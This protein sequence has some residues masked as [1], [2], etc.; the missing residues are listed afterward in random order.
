MY[1]GRPEDAFDVVIPSLPGYGFS[2]KPTEA[3]WGLPRI[4]K[5]WGVLMKRLG[6]E[7]YVPAR[8][9]SIESSTSRLGESVI[10]RRIR[11]QRLD[12]L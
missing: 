3:G 2:D 7:R 4:A 11:T 5:A 10:H 9:E 12:P 8:G 1:G 6:Y